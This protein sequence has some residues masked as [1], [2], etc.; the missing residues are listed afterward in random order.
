[1]WTNWHGCFQS[2]VRSCRVC[3]FSCSISFN[4]GV[5]ISI[6]TV[7]LFFCDCLTCCLACSTG[8][9][10][11][12]SCG[13]IPRIVK[14]LLVPKM[15]RRHK[16]TNHN[17]EMQAVLFWSKGN[18]SWRHGFD[19]SQT[20]FGI[21]NHVK[22]KQITNTK[23]TWQCNIMDCGCG[24]SRPRAGSRVKQK[25][26]T[27]RQR[28]SNSHCCGGVGDQREWHERWNFWSRQNSKS[29]LK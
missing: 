20:K 1:M 18:C 16:V 13:R 3:P 24:I 27:E 11:K 15:F 10:G 28:F 26:M 4:I 14:A 19:L 22:S 7:D 23:L 9:H 6:R 29:S 12:V 21:N 8:K 17:V 5:S 25:V 2:S